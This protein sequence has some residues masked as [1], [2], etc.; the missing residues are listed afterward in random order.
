MS[1]NT[2]VLVLSVPWL[3]LTRTSFDAYLSTHPAH[4][5]FTM[6]VAYPRAPIAW[7]PGV[8]LGDVRELAGGAQIVVERVSEKRSGRASGET[9]R[10][11]LTVGQASAAGSRV[12]LDSSRNGTPVN[13]AS[14][15][16]DDEY[17]TESDEE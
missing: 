6:A 3:I 12:S 4:F 13:G 8:V 11:S 16:D 14:N 9:S 7:A 17:L 15:A 10:A 5:R 2:S 1:P